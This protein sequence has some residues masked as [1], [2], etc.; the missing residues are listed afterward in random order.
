MI[1]RRT[2]MKH[3]EN[4]ELRGRPNRKAPDGVALTFTDRDE[5]LSVDAEERPMRVADL[6][7]N[8]RWWHA[9]F[10]DPRSRSEEH[11]RIANKGL[12]Q[13]EE[14]E[15]RGFVRLE[16]NRYDLLRK[17]AVDY[18]LASY[19]VHAPVVLD[20][21]DELVKEGEKVLAAEAAKN[22][23]APSKAKK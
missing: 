14:T 3:L 10:S 8:A 18:L 1:P 4:I 19:E 7:R 21:L 23:K 9:R 5:E 6:L 22:G 13:I 16:D 11:A 20:R 12:D 15:G 17:W 2:A